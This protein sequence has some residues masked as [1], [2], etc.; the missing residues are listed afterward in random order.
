MFAFILLIISCT[1]APDVEG[2][3]ALECRDGADNDGDSYFDCDDHDCDGS[4]DCS[5][6]DGTD[7]GN[8]GTNHEGDD[9]AAD[10]G[11][12]SG[13]DTDTDTAADTDSGADGETGVDTGDGCGDCFGITRI[14]P[15]SVSLKADGVSLD[16]TTVTLYGWATGLTVR[17][18]GSLAHLSAALASTDT[19]ATGQ[20]TVKLDTSAVWRGTETGSCWVQG[21]QGDPVSF[22]VALSPCPSCTGITSADSSELS[23]QT[24]STTY[25]IGYTNSMKFYGTA[26]GIEVWCDTSAT[27][28]AH[29]FVYSISTT[30]TSATGEGT[31]Y[32]EL[33]DARYMQT[34]WGMCEISSEQSPVL[35]IC[36]WENNGVAADPC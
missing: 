31:F 27:G 14:Y 36:V 21:D 35:S 1:S 15:D 30:D 8:G 25:P 6:S 4:P 12:D 3:A 11:A 10:T 5:T 23:F 34:E 7:T 16:T 2:D 20:T 19:S 28:L 18:D 33:T 32:I 26:T 9:S 22:G 24:Y 29:D 17:C 13:N